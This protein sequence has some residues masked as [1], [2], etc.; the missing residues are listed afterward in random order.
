MEINRCWCWL[1]DFFL[2]FPCFPVQ[3]IIYQKM[4]AKV[5]QKKSSKKRNT[6]PLVD[7]RGSLYPTSSATFFAPC[8][9]LWSQQITTGFNIWYLKSCAACIP[10][11][12]KENRICLNWE[13]NDWNHRINTWFILQSFTRVESVF[14]MSKW[15]QNRFP[16]RKAFGFLGIMDLPFIKNGTYKSS[17]IV[18]CPVLSCMVR[19][20]GELTW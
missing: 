1:A 20:S 12:H 19:T 10:L 15:K 11:L 5:C 18:N 14:W 6:S 7:P 16:T 4:I 8:E 13:K 3:S 2:S 9:G 17:R